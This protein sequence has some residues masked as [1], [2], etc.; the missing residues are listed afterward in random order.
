MK[1]RKYSVYVQYI[2]CAGYWKEFGN[3]T[4]ASCRDSKYFFTSVED[5]ADVL[6]M[7]K[8]IFSRKTYVQFI[9]FV[10][11]YEVGADDNCAS[12]ER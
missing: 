8:E 4:H 10:H 2:N 12:W 7:F 6:E 5:A 9:D 3:N 11:V 1:Q